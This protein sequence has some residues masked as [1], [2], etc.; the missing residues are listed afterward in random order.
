MPQLQSSAS[1]FFENLQVTRPRT[2]NPMPLPLT[3]GL[4][5]PPPHPTSQLPLFSTPLPSAVCTI[6]CWPPNP[7]FRAG[8]QKSMIIGCL[9]INPDD[10]VALSL[11]PRTRSILPDLHCCILVLIF[12]Y[13]AHQRGAFE[14][15][16]GP[17]WSLWVVPCPRLPVPFSRCRI[18]LPLLSMLFFFLLN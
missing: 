1:L 10:I 2:S 5:S 17:M 18:S 8:L 15:V 9:V 12:S 13:E 11:A 16:L 7:D 14:S 4:V 3:P 6:L